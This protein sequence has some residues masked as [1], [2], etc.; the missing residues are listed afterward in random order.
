MPRVM[1]LIPTASY[2]APDFMSAADKLGLDVVVASDNDQP[3]ADMYPGRWLTLPYHDVERGAQAVAR[4]ADSFPLD[5]VVAVD[6]P[7]TILAAHASAELQLNGNTPESVIGTRDK[8][9]LRR[10]LE[11]HGVR[12]PSWQVCRFDDE[13]PLG[14][15]EFPV[16]VKPLGLNG[17]RGVIRANDEASLRQAIERLRRLL[18]TKSAAAEC[19]ELA[20]RFLIEGFIPGIEVALEGL[21]R[22]GELHTLA[23]F[24]KPD[25]LD[26]PFFE[27]TIYVTPSRLPEAQI[28]EVVATARKSAEALGLQDGPLHAELRLNEEGAWPVDVA[29][30]TIG[31]LC[32][33]TLRFGA[34]MSL[35]EI[36]LRHAINAPLASLNRESTAAGVM[37][38]PIV[39]RGRIREI[40]GLDE[41]AAVPLIEEIEMEAR[42]GDVLVPLPEG[43]DYPGFI[44]ARGDDPAKVESA[45][46][47]AWSK[48]EFV[49]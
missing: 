8:S 28:D 10:A 17:S 39:G 1:L 5:A 45:L 2:R 38:M 18:S 9:E 31:G 25:P 23:V 12:S 16:V 7:G 24:D 33:R 34:G 13:P 36:V 43:A 48:I 46:R 26:G 4:Y 37:M 14:Q 15:L 44:F 47:E 20:D 41:A 22:E 11:S 19:G 32:A 27:E 29:A 42:V 21:L 30:R 49:L 35:E 3:L 40:R 6:D